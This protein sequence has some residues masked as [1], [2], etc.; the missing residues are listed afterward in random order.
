MEFSGD[1]GATVITAAATASV[2][3]TGGAAGASVDKQDAS[4]VGGCHKGIAVFTIAKGGLMYNAT[5]AGQKFTF[6]SSETASN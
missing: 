5:I 3:T 4:T 2:G 1:V 6:R